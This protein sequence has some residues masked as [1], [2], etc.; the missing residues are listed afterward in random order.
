[1]RASRVEVHGIITCQKCLRQRQS[2]FF[3]GVK[4]ISV[5]RGKN[6]ARDPMFQQ[7]SANART[8]RATLQNFLLEIATGGT[9]K[10]LRHAL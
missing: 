3:Y 9:V 10:L 5:D 2:T 8:N 6:L 1:M 7:K 4:Q